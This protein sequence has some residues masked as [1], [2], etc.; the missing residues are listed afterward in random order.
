MSDRL[1]TDEIQRM[2]PDELRDFV[3]GLDGNRIA[4]EAE[5]ARLEAEV[6]RLRSALGQYGRHWAN[7]KIQRC[8]E[9]GPLHD[10]TCGFDAALNP[11]AKEPGQ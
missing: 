5:I 3:N 4:A 9:V 11:P 8:P 2:D 6:E 10:C 1:T 7:C